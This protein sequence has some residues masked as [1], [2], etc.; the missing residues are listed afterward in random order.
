MPVAE[1]R[2]SVSSLKTVALLCGAALLVTACGGGAPTD[3]DMSEASAAVDETMAAEGAM[4]EE[5][6]RVASEFF[7]PGITAEERLALLHPDYIQH[8]PAFKKFADENGLSYYDGFAQVFAG[9]GG[10][11][12]RGG[13]RGAAD[14]DTP[15]PPP[16]NNLYLVMAEDDLVFIMRQSFRQDPNEEPGTFYE[17]FAWDTFRIRDGLLYEHW[18]GATIQAAN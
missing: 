13:G 15:Q 14:T 2:R 17:A 16:G 3:E 12:G 4:L 18:D 1:R 6:K 10:R 8:N 7:R 5:N 9:R 11:G